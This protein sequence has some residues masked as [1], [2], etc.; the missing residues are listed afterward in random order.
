VQRLMLQ[1]AGLHPSLVLE[2]KDFA[3]AL[4]YRQAPEYED[5]VVAGVLAIASM[6]E[7]EIEVQRGKSVIELRPRGASKAA[8]V[9]QFMMEPPFRGRTPVYL[10]DDLTDESAF[11][12]VNRAGGL[13]IA[14]DV[15]HP[16]VASIRFQSV[17]EVRT[18]LQS[19]LRPLD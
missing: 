7:T 3:W 4:H 8:A 13:S 17:G 9:A 19:L 14:V 2:D 12:W 1:V 15:A 6:L 5:E 10:G 16:T 11:E 18:W